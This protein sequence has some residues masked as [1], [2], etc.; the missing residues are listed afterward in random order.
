MQNILYAD[1]AGNIAIRSTGYL[2]VRSDGAGLLDETSGA[3]A[4]SGRVP[5]EELPHALNPARGFLT[6][7]NQ[8]P[9][10][11]TYPYDLGHDWR[12]TSR[13]IRIN[14]LLSSR[15]QHG[16]DDLKRYQSDVH[17]VQRDLFVPLL[18]TLGRLSPRADTLRRMLSRWDG[19]A[20]VDRP[21][22]LALEFFLRALNR[23]AWDE[24]VFGRNRRPSEPRLYFL[25]HREPAS[26]WLDV[27]AT[28]EREQAADLLRLALEEAATGLEAEFGAAPAG[29]RWGD[30][31]RVEFRHLT[32]TP[33]LRALWR[34][35]PYPG[36]ASTL[37][38]AG[39][40]PTTHSASWRVVVDFSQA[41]PVG[42]GIYP[43]GQSGNPFSTLYARHIPDYVAFNHYR[44]HK[45]DGPGAMEPGTAHSVLS[46]T[47]GR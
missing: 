35:E 36:F 24:P 22:P 38:P 30:H 20:S 16:V 15:P 45:P 25:L 14:D 7:T 42:Y 10:D 23:L 5:F 46:L 28:P 47:P 33:A 9:A 27:R 12:E 4:W 43:G 13:S 18:D 40:R 41:P 29:W 32:Q 6:S 17:A 26:D 44:L 3:A 37:S 34:S 1:A 11:S 21:E 31:H 2:P 8:Q 39:A 19:T